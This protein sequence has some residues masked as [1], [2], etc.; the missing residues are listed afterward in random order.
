MKTI[1]QS[2]VVWGGLVMS[3]SSYL[4]ALMVVLPTMEEGGGQDVGMMAMVLGAAGFSMIPAI[5]I[6]RKILF[7]RKYD[8]GGFET[9]DQLK[10][11][12][13]TVGIVSWAMSEAIAIF[14]FLLTFLSGEMIYFG[15]GAG[16]ALI[17]MLVFRPQDERLLEEYS[18]RV[19]GFGESEE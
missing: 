8:E 9:P 10:G 7:F 6:L 1:G 15:I 17:L 19:A 4:L 16:V 18:R 3:L 13:F 5:L 2:K 11:A 12:Y 14:G